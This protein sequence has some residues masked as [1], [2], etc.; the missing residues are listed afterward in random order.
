[1]IIIFTVVSGLF[2]L[3]IGIYANN[4]IFAKNYKPQKVEQVNN[5]GNNA[6]PTNITCSNSDPN[7]QIQRNINNITMTKYSFLP[8]P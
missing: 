4:K 1:M 6:G 5:C 3:T 8:F 2:S 7:T